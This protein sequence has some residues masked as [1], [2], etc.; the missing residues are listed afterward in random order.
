MIMYLMNKNNNLSNVH[1]NKTNK[2]NAYPLN[3]IE[4]TLSEFIEFIYSY[5]FIKI[6]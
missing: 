3:H 1:N 4:N 2:T 5:I 6:S